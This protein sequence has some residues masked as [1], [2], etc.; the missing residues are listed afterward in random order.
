MVG[1][2]WDIC[3]AKQSSDTSQIPGADDLKYILIAPSPWRTILNR[4]DTAAGS[5]NYG[6]GVLMRSL[7]LDELG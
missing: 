5:D 7:A 4:F 2:G 1:P 3:C 6:S